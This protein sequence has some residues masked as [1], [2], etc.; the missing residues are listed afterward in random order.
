MEQ[1]LNKK[2]EEYIIKFKEDIRA[3]LFQI[4]GVDTYKT[5]EIMEYIYDYE[6]LTFTKEDIKQKKTKNERPEFDKCIAILQ[7]GEQCTRKKKKNIQYCGGHSEL[8]NLNSNSTNNEE[9]NQIEVFS[10]NI[11]GIIYYIDKFNNVY[12]TEDVMNNIQNAR[13]IAKYNPQKRN[14]NE[15]DNIH[16]IIIFSDSTS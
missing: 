9:L 5:N 2:F 7:N 15:A 16:D 10:E 13:I 8:G 1:Q 6:R 14:G 11:G 3:K 4:N 12:N